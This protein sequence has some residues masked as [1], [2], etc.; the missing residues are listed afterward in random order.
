MLNFFFSPDYH[1]FKHELITNLEMEEGAV[2]SKWNKHGQR[3]LQLCIQQKKDLLR[4]VLPI[5]LHK[6]IDGPA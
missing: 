5:S 2:T 1:S 4:C 6:Q 3:F